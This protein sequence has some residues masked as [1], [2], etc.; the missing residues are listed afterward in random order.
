MAKL[1]KTIVELQKQTKGIKKWKARINMKKTVSFGARS[2]SD[3]TKHKDAKRQKRYIKR[4]KA[5][6]SWTKSGIKTA[7]FW[8]RWLLW[9]KTSIKA[10]AKNI[11]SKFGIKIKFVKRFSK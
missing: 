10:S 2:Y 5:K 6:E 3:F 11:E 8:S 4:H 1:R 9:N 7:G